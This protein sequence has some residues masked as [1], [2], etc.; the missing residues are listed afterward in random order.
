MQQSLLHNGRDLPPSIR[1][2]LE[3]LLGRPLKDNETVSIRTYESHQVPSQEVRETALRGLKRHLAQIDEQVQ[4][5]PKEEHE[6]AI[7]EALRS[8]RPAYR[9]VR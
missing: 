1:A 7:E 8:V 4:D 5:V 2:A 6:E 9:P 3:T